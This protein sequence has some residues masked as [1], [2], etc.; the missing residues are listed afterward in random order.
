MYCNEKIDS[1][2]SL[3]STNIDQL[4]QELKEEYKKLIR[5]STEFDEIAAQFILLQRKSLSE[6]E[7]EYET[8]SIVDKLYLQI[9]TTFGSE[10]DAN[11]I[12]EAAMAVM[13]ETSNA[14]AMSRN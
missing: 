13:D 1:M 6:P 2:L 11:L 4:E 9:S 7:K 5:I 3:I 14:V 8:T 10:R 12:F